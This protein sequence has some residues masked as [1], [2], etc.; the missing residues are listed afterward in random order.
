MGRVGPD[1]GDITGTAWSELVVELYSVDL[2]KCIHEFKYGNRPSCADIEDL[3][4]LLHLSFNHPGYGGDMSLGKVHDIYVVPLAGA[5]RSRI[6]VAEDAQTF[7]LAD[8]CLGNVRHEVVRHAA[9]KFAD[10][11]GRMGADRIEVSEGYAFYRSLPVHPCH[12]LGSVCR[13][14]LD[15]IPQDVFRN[16]LC[17]AVR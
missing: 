1:G 17:V 5:V 16:L 11:G 4:I 7:T 15:R 10:E 2:L 8:G 13:S 6:V 9:G 3:V 14:G 12:D